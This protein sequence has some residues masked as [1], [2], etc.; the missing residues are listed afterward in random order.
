MK[1][2]YHPN[3]RHRRLGEMTTV[4]GKRKSGS[5]DP[6]PASR[7]TTFSFYHPPSPRLTIKPEKAECDKS[8][9]QRP[10]LPL[11]QRM[12]CTGAEKRWI[13]VSFPWSIA[14]STNGS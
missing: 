11:L 5:I 8:A 9:S 12:P 2:E 14:R 13:R 10:A 6:Y 1:A 7:P 3:G 4:L